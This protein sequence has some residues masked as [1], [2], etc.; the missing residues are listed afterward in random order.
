MLLSDEL[1]LGYALQAFGYAF[2]LGPYWATVFHLYLTRAGV[3]SMADLATG[4]R[5]ETV[6]MDLDFFGVEQKLSPETMQQL[7]IFLPG[8][9][10]YR[11]F[12]LAQKAAEKVEQGAA[13][14]KYVHRPEDGKKGDEMF[15][16]PAEDTWKL[17]VDC[18]GFVRSVLKHVTKDPFV[19]ALS[20]RGFMRAKDFY[21]FFETVP[22]NVTDKKL[23]VENTEK[24][25][26]MK[27]RIVRDLRMVIPGKDDGRIE[28]FCFGSL[29]LGLSSHLS[30]HHQE[31]SLCIDLKAMQRVELHLLQMTAATSDIC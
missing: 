2:G 21:R 1:Q 26:R 4:C 11:C 15:T 12:R 30:L 9:M 18:A 22:Y 13:D 27:W 16:T 6:N 10:G 23:T 25:K 29:F 31:I 28:N 20:D 8:P 17:H 19:L 14:A 3:A 5:A 7:E 24:D